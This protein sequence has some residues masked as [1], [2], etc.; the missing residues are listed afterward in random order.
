MNLQNAINWAVRHR[1]LFLAL[2]GALLCMSFI[3]LRDVWYPDEPDIAEVALAMF[4]SG[5]W[6]APRRMGVVWVDYPPMIYWIGVLSSHL[7]GDM[8]AFTLRFP[9]AILAI[10]TV[11]LTCATASRWYDATTGLWAGFALLTSL[12]FV[13]EAN[14]YRPDI[15]FAISIAAGLVFYA[16]GTIDRHRLGL[17]VAGFVFLGLAMLSKGILGLLLPGLVLVLWHASRK[18]WRRILE[19]APLSLVSLAVFLPWV[20]GTALSMGWENLL[21]EFYAQNFA[22]FHSGFRGHEQAPWYYV[23]NFWL[24]FSPWS[25]L[26]PFALLWSRR[27][28][29]L[30]NARFQLL[31]WWFGTFLV[32]LSLAETKRQLYM[33][34]AFPAFA[35]LIGPWLSSVGK[36]NS[37]DTLTSLDVPREKPIHV[38]SLVMALAFVATGLAMGLLGVFSGAVGSRIGLQP[39]ELDVAHALTWPLI[40]LGV[41]L[42]IAGSWIGQTWRDRDTRMALKRIALSH[43]V[44]YAVVLGLLMPAFA[45]SK[46]YKP[47]GEWIRDQVGPGESHIG[48][49]YPNGG[50]IR[51]R[52]AFG[53]ETEGLLVDLLETREDVATFFDHYP[54]S[55]VLVESSSMPALFGD[56]PDAWAARTLRE[57]GVGSTRYLVIGAGRESCD[58]SGRESG[59]AIDRPECR[60]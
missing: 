57:L 45:P 37:T 39:N 15:A 41:V 5:D 6:I 26:F 18:E 19:L 27:S 43:V 4:Q 17:R 7:F 32:F 3:G 48:M 38:Y 34:P 51:K 56:D 12:L 23:V 16:D 54:G 36:V 10:V 47:Q 14:S 49:V 8:T 25:W 44:V 21:H 24:D 35:L 31:L 20:A 53:F 42:I 28:G 40:L 1:F 30:K 50:G 11:L 52:G 29:L 22:R 46:T 2:T 59:D 13:Y 33:L 58:E 9:N 60:H 55:L